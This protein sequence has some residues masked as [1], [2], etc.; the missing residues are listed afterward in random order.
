MVLYNRDKKCAFVRMTSTTTSYFFLNR[1]NLNDLVI[2]DAYTHTNLWQLF[3]E[4]Q[5]KTRTNI[6][7]IIS[8]LPVEISHHYETIAIFQFSV[9]L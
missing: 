9:K 1:V 3:D 7:V 8:P 4:I 6:C 5:M 2:S